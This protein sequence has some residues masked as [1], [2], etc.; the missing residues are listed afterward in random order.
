MENVSASK[1][2]LFYVFKTT[3]PTPTLFKIVVGAYVFLNIDPSPIIYRTLLVVT[4]SYLIVCII[5]HI[6]IFNKP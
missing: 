2:D 5:T 4:F 1:R 6:L 3:I